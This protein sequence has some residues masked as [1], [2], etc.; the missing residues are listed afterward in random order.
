NET[1]ITSTF[2]IS[3]TNFY[4]RENIIEPNFI[5]QVKMKIAGKKL[6]IWKYRIRKEEGIVIASEP[7]TGEL[8]PYEVAVVNIWVYADTWGTYYDKLTCHITGLAPYIIDLEAH[9]TGFPLSFPM[10]Y[11]NIQNKTILRFG[12]LYYHGESQKR[13]VRIKNESNVNISVNWHV[14]IT[15]ENNAPCNPFNLSLDIFD[16]GN[17]KLGSGSISGNKLHENGLYSQEMRLNII[18]YY[19]KEDFIIFQIRPG[20]ITIPAKKE[21][22]FFIR[23]NPKI[24]NLHITDTLHIKA[25]AIGYLRISEFDSK[26][27][28]HFVRP[29]GVDMQPVILHMEVTI[30]MPLFTMHHTKEDVIF[31][32]NA[33]DV[34]SAYSQTYTVNR[35]FRFTNNKQ[36]PLSALIRTTGLFEILRIKSL[37]YNIKQKALRHNINLNPGQS[38]EIQIGCFFDGKIIEKALQTLKENDYALVDETMSLSRTVTLEGKLYLKQ[39]NL[40]QQNLHLSVHVTFPHLILH[41]ETLD[42]GAVFLKDTKKLP[43]LIQNR[44]A[45]PVQI[46]VRMKFTVEEYHIEPEDILL[47]PSVASGKN[48]TEILISFTP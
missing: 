18:P 20:D 19:G 13:R 37:D 25:V 14:F 5:E 36:A 3:I 1:P 40:I 27:E 42:F 12:V 28:D 11:G 15:E 47:P 22:S 30:E 10:S 2:K 24:C 44:S 9:I 31:R 32:V 48:I 43:L 39:H 41:A 34:M 6:D 8:G 38:A 33:I 29:S 17:V 21:T 46:H 45:V 7:S 35:T 16:S 26:R 23:V 4:E